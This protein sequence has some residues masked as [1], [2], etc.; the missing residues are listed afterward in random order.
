LMRVLV[1]GK[2]A[3]AGPVGAGDIP[4]QGSQS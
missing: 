4:R 2:G 1:M 3:V